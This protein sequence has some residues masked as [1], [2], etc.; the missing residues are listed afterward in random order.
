MKKGVV[1]TWTQEV[2]LPLT[3]FIAYYLMARDSVACGI[4]NDKFEQVLE[5]VLPSGVQA[6]EVE[7]RTFWLIVGL[8]EVGQFSRAQELL[9]KFHPKDTRFLLAIHLGCALVEYLRVA[10][11][12]E[13][14]IAG[15]IAHSLAQLI[16]PIRSQLLSEFKT[17]LLEVRMGKV[18]AIEPPELDRGESEGSK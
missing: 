14:E 9:A 2:H 6:E 5:R 7:A 18:H 8:I 1:E 4:L 10:T 11:K 12:E 15:K 3:T 16:S 13:R 17:H